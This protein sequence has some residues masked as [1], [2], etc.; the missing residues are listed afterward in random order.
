MYLVVYAE[1][2]AGLYPG[3]MVVGQETSDGS[4]S[5]FGFRFNPVELP[6]DRRSPIHW[7]EFF[8]SNAVP[9]TIVDESGYVRHLLRSDDRKVYEK[10]VECSVEL[11]PALPSADRWNPHA[12]YSF[13]PDTEHPGRVPC[14]NCV[15]WAIVVAN[16]LLAN[17]LPDVPQGRL[18]L[19]L[20]HLQLIRP[21]AP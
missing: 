14:Y 13:Y 12:W 4:A 17:F 11:R 18:K 7:Q 1:A 15:K 19:A 21:K 3:H 16:S 20:Q 8:A 9:G 5:Y 2:S 10:R 6:S